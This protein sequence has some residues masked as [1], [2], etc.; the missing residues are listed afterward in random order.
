[1][2]TLLAVADLP[3]DSG[4]LLQAMEQVQPPAFR[5][6]LRGKPEVVEGIVKW[7]GELGHAS[8]VTP[9]RG[10]NPRFADECE[11]IS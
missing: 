3:N 8:R 7:I 4:Q 5:Q 10:L 9:K 2:S 6:L 1:M 11:G